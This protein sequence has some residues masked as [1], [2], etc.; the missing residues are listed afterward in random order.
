MEN[1]AYRDLLAQHPADYPLFHQPWWLD[2]ACGGPDRWQG[3][4]SSRSYQGARAVMPVPLLPKWRVIPTVRRPLLTPYL[5][6]WGAKLLSLPDRSQFQFARKLWPELIAQLPKVPYFHQTFRPELVHALPF[7]T[8]GYRLQLR[9]SY[10]LQPGR[11]NFNR[12]HRRALQRA[13]ELEVW[14][15]DSSD[16]LYQLLSASFARQEQ[17]LPFSASLMKSLYQAAATHGHS[18]IW[19][20]GPDRETPQAAIWVLSDAF[21]NY[22][23]SNGVNT[24]GRENGAYP[25]LIAHLITEPPQPQLPIDL[26]G[27]M[28]PAVAEVNVGMGAVAKLVIELKK[29]G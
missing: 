26:C 24:A 20:T 1:L 28:L 25:R 8:A 11:L 29:G 17:P 13:E 2:A 19:V 27:T 15:V 12:N 23:L 5:G 18:Q 14:S 10:R 22:V 6:P 16:I 4:L 21:C 3:L 7:H 9:Y